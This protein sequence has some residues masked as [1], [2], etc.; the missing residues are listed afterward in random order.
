VVVAV[1]R[2]APEEEHRS[3]LLIGWFVAPCD[4]LN[5]ANVSCITAQ[6]FEN[7]AHER[8]LSLDLLRRL[9]QKIAMSRFFHLPAD[10]APTSAT[11]S[12]L[13]LQL[14]PALRDTPSSKEA[15]DEDDQD[16]PDSNDRDNT[17]VH[18]S[19][20]ARA[21]S[22]GRATDS[23]ID[24]AP[25]SNRSAL[26][27]IHQ[28]EQAS[29]LNQNEQM[30]LDLLDKTISTQEILAQRQHEMA[31]VINLHGDQLQR[32]SSALERVESLLFD[33]DGKPLKRLA[34]KPRQAART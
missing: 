27:A 11:P 23:S 29:Q 9:N 7:Q 28:T 25:E 12:T 6:A 19:G 32:I 14:R 13:Q 4:G 22:V 10:D 3:G 30:L 2:N 33:K 26:V 18:T 24:A 16:G 20:S 34:R 5:A 17:V 31:G 1:A 8:N 21:T 15:T